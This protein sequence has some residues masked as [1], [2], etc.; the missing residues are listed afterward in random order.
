MNFQ[1]SATQRMS[2]ELEMVIAGVERLRARAEAW[3][4]GRG[5][6]F[7]RYL[8]VLEDRVADVSAALAKLDDPDPDPA[9]FDR[10]ANDVKDAKLRLAIARRAA[11]A[12]FH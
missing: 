3:A 11:R 10:I 8:D 12:R 1:E 2:A 6:R 5:G 9:S 4:P 7:G